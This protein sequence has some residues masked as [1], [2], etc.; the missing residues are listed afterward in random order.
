MGKR[1]LLLHEI[2]E[3]PEPVVEELLEIVRFRKRDPRERDLT[4]LASETALGRDW[5]R[6]EEDDAWRDL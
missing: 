1:E 3:A 2:E 4:T 6:P 5:L